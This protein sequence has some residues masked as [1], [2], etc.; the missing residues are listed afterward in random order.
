MSFLKYANIYT[1]WQL[2][3]CTWN[4]NLELFELSPYVSMYVYMYIWD[5]DSPKI[6]LW[7]RDLINIISFYMISLYILFFIKNRIICRILSCRFFRFF[8]LSFLLYVCS[9][10]P[11]MHMEIAVENPL[12][13]IRLASFAHSLVYSIILYRIISV[14]HTIFFWIKLL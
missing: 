7:G 14:V 12:A 8:T 2:I 11:Q 6:E 5:F 3:K 1:R 10:D 13:N 9:Y 4:K